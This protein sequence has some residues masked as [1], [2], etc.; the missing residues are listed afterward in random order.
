[1][2]SPDGKW[3]WDG[4]QWQPIAHHES[5][6]PSWQS[7]AAEPAAPV[8]QVAAAPVAAAPMAPAA[9]FAPAAIP[10]PAPAIVQPAVNPAMYFPQAPQQATP[11][12]K[13]GREAKPTGMNNMLYIAAGVVVIVIILVVLNSVFPLWLLL[14]GPKAAAAPPPP[15]ASPVPQLTV[16]S[17]YGRADYFI[18]IQLGKELETLN[19]DLTATSQECTRQLTNSCETALTAVIPDIKTTV[20]IIDKATLPQCIAPQVAKVRADI[21]N[22]QSALDVAESAYNHNQGSELAFAMGTFVRYRAVFS[23]DVGALPAIAKAKCDP[24]ETGP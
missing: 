14:P 16:R 21:M 13:R 6:F 11:L 4:Q 10:G 1:M 22:M 8:A 18:N 20:G 19:P 15:K 5:V 24:T 23:G 3:V 9:P 17:D 7:I 2:L 12:W